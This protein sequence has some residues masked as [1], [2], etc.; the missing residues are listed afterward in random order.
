MNEV[1]FARIVPSRA[2][3]LHPP[4]DVLPAAPLAPPCLSAIDAHIGVGCGCCL[5]LATSTEVN[6]LV[7]RPSRTAAQD[8]SRLTVFYTRH[9]R[10]KNAMVSPCHA[11]ATALPCMRAVA[12]GTRASRIIPCAQ[13][14]D[15]VHQ[16]HGETRRDTPVARRMFQV[17]GRP[18]AGR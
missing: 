7:L 9:E 12:S 14:T 10:D 4:S 5:A 6:W 15:G 11:I 18:G 1:N 17:T 8:G 2:H 16:V 3:L 13:G